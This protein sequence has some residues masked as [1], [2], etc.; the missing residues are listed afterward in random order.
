MHFQITYE[1]IYIYTLMH[2][3]IYKCMNLLGMY[4]Q[5]LTLNNQQQLIWHKTHPSN[6]Y[7]FWSLD[8]TTAAQFHYQE[9]HE[10]YLYYH[11]QKLWN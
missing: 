8:E 10:I 4:M 7:T 5:D 6:N 11:K 3:D 2:T 9:V 1:Y